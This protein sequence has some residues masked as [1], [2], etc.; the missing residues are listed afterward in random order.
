MMKTYRFTL[1]GSPSNLNLFSLFQI[2]VRCLINYIYAFLNLC[3]FIHFG[4]AAML[5]FILGFPVLPSHGIF[6]PVQCL[7]I[8]N[9]VQKVAL[10]YRLSQQNFHSYDLFFAHAKSLC[11]VLICR[12]SPSMKLFKILMKGYF[13]RLLL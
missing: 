12:T 5:S 3:L 2:S 8:A 13:S 10:T 9:S 1:S 4:E 7:N 6:T 11:R